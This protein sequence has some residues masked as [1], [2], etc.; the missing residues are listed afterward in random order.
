MTF[1]GAFQKL[2]QILSSTGKG[3]PAQALAPFSH[4]LI[5]EFRT[6]P[7]RSFSG[8]RRCTAHWRAR[9]RRSA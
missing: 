9:A 7:R 3:A 1:N 8:C 2:T 6:S 5:D 4:L